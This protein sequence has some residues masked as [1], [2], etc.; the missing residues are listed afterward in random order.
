MAASHGVRLKAYDVAIE[1]LKQAKEASG[2]ETD[3][4]GVYGA[5]RR[6]S[7]LKFKTD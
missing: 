1:H 7:G 4:L 5:V 3:I 6:E 2:G